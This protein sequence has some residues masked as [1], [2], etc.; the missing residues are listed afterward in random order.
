MNDQ[1]L[2]SGSNDGNEVYKQ[3]RF[4]LQTYETVRKRRLDY[5]ERKEYSP[6]IIVKKPPPKASNI[7]RLARVA[8][9]LGYVMFNTYYWVAFLASDKL[10]TFPR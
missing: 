1:S 3:H 5:T 7:D 6:S 4:S 10:K 9:P 2:Q 8:L